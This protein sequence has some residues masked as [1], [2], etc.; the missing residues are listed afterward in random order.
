MS[1]LGLFRVHAH[2]WR[3]ILAINGLA[4]GQRCAACKLSVYVHEDYRV[5]GTERKA[6]SRVSRWDLDHCLAKAGLAIE[7]PREED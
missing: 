5:L 1:F 6:D 4:I 3:P 2:Q 7:I